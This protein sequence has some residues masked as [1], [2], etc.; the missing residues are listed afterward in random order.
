MPVQQKKR[1]YYFFLTVSF[2]TITIKLFHLQI[3]NLTMYTEYS[4]RNR[5]RRLIVQPTRGL[6]LDRNGKVLVDNRPAYSVR[7]TPFELRKNDS[8]SVVLSR[9]L[10][11]PVENLKKQVNASEGP[12]VPVKISSDVPYDKLVQIEEHKLELPGVVYDVEPRRMYPTDIYASHLFGYLGEIS[13]SELEQRKA[14]GFQ[15]G[16]MIGKKGIEKIYDDDLRGQVG[17]N[18]VEVNAYGQEVADIT[19]K[20]EQPAKAGNDIY[21]TIDLSIQEVAEKLFEGISGGVVML[22]VRNGGVLVLCSK[23]DYDPNIF[24]GTITNEIWRDL[25]NDPRKVLFDRMIQS[26]FPPGSTYKL[27]MVAAG[28]DNG[29]CDVNTSTV[30]QGSVTFGNH[31]FK[32]WKAK[33]HGFVTLVDAIK[34]SCNSFFYRLSMNVGIDYWS[35]TS[36]RF[37]FGRPTGIDLPDESPGNVPD[38]ASLDSLFGKDKWPKGTILNL[39][40]GQ[41]E[42]LVTP[43]QMAQFAMMIANEGSY[44]RPHVL[45]KKHDPVTHVESVYQPE[46]LHVDGVS[47][48]SYSII[49][50]GMYRC[51]NEP[52]GTGRASSLAQY[53][54]AGKTGTAQNPGNED[55][56]WFIGFAPFEQPE[57]AIC[58]LVENGGSGGGKA[59]P[60]A[61]QVLQK[62]FEVTRPEP[63]KPVQTIAMK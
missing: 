29:K 8:V 57:V 18:F 63:P 27:V 59:A 49:K 6:I 36:K 38:R 17:T 42:L 5:I 37:G 39:G 31:T 1:V 45:L 61:R 33:G 56:A 12:F 34:V 24:T 44:F 14:D 51:V 11:T 4:E 30:C 55:H 52:G 20:G 54:V 53:I 7:I 46:N 13:K 9:L 28:L 40:I 35:D 2:I 3:Y 16:D 62:Y 60:I 43:V 41:G 48:Y 23:P 25:V 32:C 21:L 26:E 58:V 50:E 19:A 15:Q 22:D 47:N 10:N